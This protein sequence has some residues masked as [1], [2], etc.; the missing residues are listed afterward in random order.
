MYEEIIIFILVAQGAL[1]TYFLLI[2]YKKLQNIIT[3]NNSLEKNVINKFDRLLNMLDSLSTLNP[4]MNK[5]LEHIYMKEH[6]SDLHSISEKIHSS[7]IKMDKLLN[8]DYVKNSNPSFPSYMQGESQTKENMDLSTDINDALNKIK[9]ENI[10]Q[11]EINTTGA[12]MNINQD[13]TGN[14]IN[15]LKS[16]EDDII[17]ALKR[18]EKVKSD[19]KQNI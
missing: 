2:I 5:N 4:E 12:D 3:Y 17:I 8:S 16:L 15:E 11:H 1:L 19:S 13:V 10:K 6:L 18:L 7:L 9:E 14:S